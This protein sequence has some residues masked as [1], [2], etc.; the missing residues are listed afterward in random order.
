MKPFLLAAVALTVAASLLAAPSRALADGAPPSSHQLVW[1]SLGSTP[2][3]GPGV[4]DSVVAWDPAMGA[5]VLYSGA[6]A[7]SARDTTWLSN[8]NGFT[9]ATVA[10][11]PAVS[12]IGMTFD[13]DR[14]VLILLGI[15]AS[16]A[17]NIQTWSYD[18]HSWRQIETSRRPPALRG[19]A[20]GYDES[21]SAVVMFGGLAN[22]IPVNDTWTFDG[23]DWTQQHGTA[24]SSRADAS[25]AWD[26]GSDGLVLFGGATT[27]TDTWV[28][29]KGAWTARNALSPPPAGR[30]Q[31]VTDTPLGQALLIGRDW[32][33]GWH[34]Y[35]WNGV[36]GQWTALQPPT[37]AAPPVGVF[38]AYNDRPAQ[39]VVILGG[40]TES[41]PLT[42]YSANTITMPSEPCAVTVA[43]GHVATSA[44]LLG[45]SSSYGVEL[46]SERLSD[47]TATSTMVAN[48]K[49][50]P[51]LLVGFEGEVDKSGGGSSSSGQSASG[52]GSGKP[53][54]SGDASVQLAAANSSGWEW[55]FPTV[56]A[57]Q[58]FNNGTAAS[59]AQHNLVQV[60]PVWGS[61]IADHTG[62]VV[63]PTPTKD[64]VVSGYALDLQASYSR[65]AADLS[66]E[67]STGKLSGG[68]ILFDQATGHQTGKTVD[69]DLSSKLAGSFGVGFKV[70][71]A[72][73]SVSAGLS[74][75]GSVDMTGEIKVDASGQPT[76]FNV[77]NKA[78]GEISVTGSGG[79]W[80]GN[81]GI[82]GLANKG[83][84]EVSQSVLGSATE[85]KVTL[86]LD[87]S[88]ALTAVS[89]FVSALNQED[90][91]K[92][93]V[94]AE[95]I[96]RLADQSGSDTVLS[97]HLD[98]GETAFGGKY[99]EVLALVGAGGDY[100]NSVETLKDA[101]FYD[102]ASQSYRSWTSCLATLR[103]PVQRVIPAAYPSMPGPFGVF[104]GQYAG[105]T[106]S[107]GAA[108][109]TG[110]GTGRFQDVDLTACPTCSTA[111]APRATVDFK[112]TTVAALGDPGYYKATGV[113][114]AES[115]P[116]DAR[117]FAG[118]VGATVVLSMLPQGDLA[119]SFL[120][121]N[122]LLSR[123]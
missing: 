96:R 81:L 102:S 98:S 79:L 75:E 11:E 113:I 123:Q 17:T 13:P 116:A 99:G 114:T 3:T 53:S 91:I 104:A 109:I 16:A 58:E 119:I 14:N 92:Q 64:Y 7:R 105:Q 33:G 74:G 100:G 101:L 70:N 42:L 108:V 94:D 39:R 52:S 85:H 23:S 6:A 9:P 68:G 37:P 54:F 30:Y 46:V 61:W 82:K 2:S 12:P 25:L 24:P 26:P 83:D 73:S 32:S 18:G 84:V 48:Q 60:V 34:E 1:K 97:Y 78:E 89:S 69:F 47:A 66:V 27:G 103:P 43:G 22:G 111:H 55:H 50:G 8:A 36:A 76:E 122:D 93:V 41:A 117:G 110:D 49:F 86:P 95:Q 35:V 120:P 44:T 31:L 59:W 56:P 88:A 80:E 38:L 40:A 5:A 67:A 77:I 29:S 65:K 51:E 106:G 62:E 118:P 90:S 63:F 45:F 21:S 115:D 112:L 57:A 72:G 121:A 15:N 10:A 28:W 107:S 4:V 19:A 20:V 71:P 87:S